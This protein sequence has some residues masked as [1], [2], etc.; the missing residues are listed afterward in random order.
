MSSKARLDVIGPWS[1][2]KLN[3]VKEYAAAY[4]TILT[5]HRFHHIFVDAFAGR[6]VHFSGR[7][8]QY[9]SGSPQIGLDTEPPF[10]E[11]IFI[12]RDPNRA[13]ELRRLAP[14][15]RKVKVL[16]GDSNEILHSD[17]FPYIR[18]EKERRALLFVDP[19]NLGFEWSVIRDAGE[20]R[21]V[22]I[23][24]NFMM[25]DA[26]MNVLRRDPNSIDPDQAAR[27]T[28]AWGDETWFNK[29]YERSGDLFETERREKVS[30]HS[31]A[32][33]FA[34]RIKDAAGFDYVAGPY[35]MTNEHGSVIY[36]LYLASQVPAAKKIISDI[37]KKYRA[38]GLC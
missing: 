29:A 8:Q 5:K 10:Q 7:L 17:V 18:Q 22:D 4:S 32:T 27:M 26:S 31:F 13:E 30:S 11:L 1:E 21:R 15:S 35:P 25:M 38:R 24:L 34:T 12:E 37:F 33:A 23:I 20:S 14:V 19:Y 2:I 3:I 16:A 6:G 9:V 36:Y 28:R